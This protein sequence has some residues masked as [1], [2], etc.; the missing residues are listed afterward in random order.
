MDQ[1]IMR[2]HIDQ[3]SCVKNDKKLIFVE[4]LKL[5]CDKTIT[6]HFWWVETVDSVQWSL[7]ILEEHDMKINY[8][9]VNYKS[10]E[11]NSFA[12]SNNEHCLWRRIIIISIV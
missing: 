12:D 11:K 3:I 7:D 4:N 1:V 8:Y 5:L 10:E 2:V 9:R 6:G